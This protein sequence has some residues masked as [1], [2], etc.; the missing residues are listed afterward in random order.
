MIKLNIAIKL[1]KGYEYSYCIKHFYIFFQ[2]D[3]KAKGT[4]NC[5][6]HSPLIKSFVHLDVP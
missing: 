4:I 2:S 5:V 1:D 6:K 3:S